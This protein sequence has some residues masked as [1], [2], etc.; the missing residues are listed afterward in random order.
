MQYHVP[1]NWF[2]LVV[3][4]VLLL[5][6]KAGRKHGM[7]EELMVTTQWVVI[8]IA[9]AFLYKPFGDML[10]QS[11]P[12]SHLFCY[13]T[14]YIT[15]A[16][17]TKIFFSLIKKAIGGKLVGSSVF[18]AAEYY[19]GMV[20]GGVRYSCML[21]AGLAILNAPHYTAQEIAMAHAA[22][23]QNFGSNF[24]PEFSTVQQGVFKESFV[25]SL[26]KQRAPILLIVSTKKENIQVQRRKDDLP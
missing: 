10:A 24:F 14:I 9:G 8:V 1:V 7:S 12:V 22:Q 17:V 3:I 5:G 4:I 15:A 18:G 6:F 23:I 21:I 16:I 19:L 25:G 26:I 20:A 11:S 13:I 2:D